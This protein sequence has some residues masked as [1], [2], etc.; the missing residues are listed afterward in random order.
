MKKTVGLFV[1]ALVLSLNFT[2]AFA[3]SKDTS[4]SLQDLQKETR[5]LLADRQKHMDEITKIEVRLNELGPM[6]NKLTPKPEPVVE[7]A[8]EKVKESAV[9]KGSQDKTAKVEVQQEEQ[10]APVTQVIQEETKEA[11]K[12]EVKD[13]KK[14]VKK[15]GWF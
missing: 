12:E 10:P 13:E 1:V 11:V 9:S 6:I 14:E 5:A 15:S 3:S 8:K 2:N 7:K 4:S